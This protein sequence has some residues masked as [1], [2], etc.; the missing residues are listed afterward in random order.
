MRRKHLG[1]PQC[2]FEEGSPFRARLSTELRD[3]PHEIKPLLWSGANSIFVRDQSALNLAQHLSAEHADHPQAAQ[4]VIA[5]SHGGNV[6]LRA[7]H[8][9]HP[10]DDSRLREGDGANPAVVTLA[11][12]FIEV[13]HA[14]FGKRPALIRAALVAAL[15]WP[16]WVLM[17]GH[18]SA[19][20][21]DKLLLISGAVTLLFGG[22]VWWFGSPKEQI[23]GDRNALKS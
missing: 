18:F 21:V 4:L 17:K 6:A 13:Q 10:S 3:I 2:W 14:D 11:T 23:S 15:W 7:L 22:F 1:P 5:H 9:L 8:F 12:P 20:E 16:I 19:D